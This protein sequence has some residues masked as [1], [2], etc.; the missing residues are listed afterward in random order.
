MQIPFD[1]VN[2]TRHSSPTILVAPNLGRAGLVKILGLQK[3]EDITI[4]QTPKVEVNLLVMFG[5]R[6]RDVW[7]Q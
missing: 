7:D 4:H 5:L 3:Y 1:C 2:G 6:G